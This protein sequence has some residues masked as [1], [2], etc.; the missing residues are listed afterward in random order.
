MENLGDG[1]CG[2][3]WMVFTKIKDW[4]S[5]SIMKSSDGSVV[6]IAGLRSLPGIEA[7]NAITAG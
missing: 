2:C 3:G 6:K 1:V 4:V 5:Q 7:A